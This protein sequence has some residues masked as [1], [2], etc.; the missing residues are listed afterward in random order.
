MASYPFRIMEKSA[1]IPKKDRRPEYKWLLL[2]TSTYDIRRIFPWS[3]SGWMNVHLLPHCSC[4]TKQK[5]L[6]EPRTHASSY[7]RGISKVKIGSATYQYRSSRTAP[8]PGPL[9]ISFPRGTD[10]QN[11]RWGVNVNAMSDTATKSP[12]YSHSNWSIVLD[13]QTVK[14]YSISLPLVAMSI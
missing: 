7:C 4:A 8:M 6:L 14:C 10:R 3:S 1:S 9:C 12:S 11:F 5:L 2:F 13:E